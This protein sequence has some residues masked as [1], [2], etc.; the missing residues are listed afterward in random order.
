MS[1]AIGVW[2]VK[3]KTSKHLSKSRRGPNTG[4]RVP[5]GSS[6]SRS[7]LMFQT[8]LLEYAQM[9]IFPRLLVFRLWRGEDPRS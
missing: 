5:K 4:L 3:S 2:T 9:W 7:D 1:W 6:A 8:P